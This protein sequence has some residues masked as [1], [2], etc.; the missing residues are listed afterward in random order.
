MI[1][2]MLQPLLQLLMLCALGVSLAAVRRPSS[3]AFTLTFEEESLPSNLLE[4]PPACDYQFSP[5]LRT[6]YSS[7]LAR[8]SGPGFGSLNGGVIV[9][10][11]A[12]SSGNYPPLSN[13]S[14]SGDQ[15]LGFSTL[16]A[17]RN[18]T[19]KPI[20]PETVRFDARVSNI[21]MK[22]AGIDGHELHIE[23]Y[24]GAKDT[25]NDAGDLVPCTLPTMH[26]H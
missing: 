17:L 9:R 6:A 8:F 15:F 26:S 13:A 2:P 22:V 14:V 3:A 4:T 1:G 21:R 18:R 16:H 20:G 25:Y 19:G 23:L 12:L 10:R 24:D 7:K 11:C 5:V